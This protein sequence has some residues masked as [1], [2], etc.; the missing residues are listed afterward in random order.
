MIFKKFC[1]RIYQVVLLNFMHIIK[2]NNKAVSKEGAVYYIP[3]ILKKQGVTGKV[4]VITGPHIAKTDIFRKIIKVFKEKGTDC[5]IFS[6]TSQETGIDSIE[7][8]RWLYLYK[9]CKAII[10]IGG[11]SVMD[12]AKAAAAGITNPGKR[13]NRFAGYQK[14]R[15]KIPVIVAVP[16]TAGTGA[17]VTACAVIRDNSTGV[18]RIIADTGIIPRF[19]VLDP[20]MTKKLPSHMAAYSGMDALT[21]ATEAYLN[22][23]TSKDARKDAEMAIKLIAG[24]IIKVYYGNGGSASRQKMLEASYLAGRAFVRTSVGYVHAIGHAIGGKYNVAHG[25]AVAVVLP[26]V[27]IWYGK[28]IYKKLARLSD[29]CGI[30]EKDLP[31]SQKAKAYINYI[32]M[33]GHKFGINESFNKALKNEHISKKDIK[34]MAKYAIIESNPHYPVPK[35]MSLKECEYIIYSICNISCG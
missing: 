29:I 4:L 35:I 34:N 24:N 23:Y 27:L 20:L 30:T 21:Y 15:K 1:Y 9:N 7:S 18:K 6:G 2:Y 3:E 10:A 8:A 16:T 28:C 11:G 13:I 31:E 12:C 19:A 14:V 33:L 5:V 32:K 17:E 26:Y 22:K 25:M